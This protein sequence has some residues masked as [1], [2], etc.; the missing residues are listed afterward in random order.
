MN[1]L[2]YALS[3]MSGIRSLIVHGL[4]RLWGREGD[5]QYQ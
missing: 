1:R 3:C 4:L 5:L 2:T